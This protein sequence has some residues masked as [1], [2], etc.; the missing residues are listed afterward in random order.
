M[1]A[2]IWSE[3]QLRMDFVTEDQAMHKLEVLPS[4]YKTVKAH[5]RQSNVARIRQSTPDFGLGF[6]VKVRQTFH[7]TQSEEQRRIDLVIY[8]GTSLIRKRPTP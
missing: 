3:Q 8:R 4:R 7:V 2:I 5:I 6:R 1:R